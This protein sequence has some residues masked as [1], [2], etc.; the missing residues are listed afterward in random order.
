MG[1]LKNRWAMLALLF[2][3][4]ASMAMQF[5]LIPPIVPFLIEDLGINFTQVGLL[6]GLFMAAGIFLALPAGLLGQRFGDKA[7]VLTGLAV[8]T[9]GAVLFANAE[10]F[11]LAF[12][13]RLLGGVGVVLLNVQL[14]K[15]TA[16]W[17][18]DKEI[19]TAMGIL[20]TAWPLGLST[21]GYVATVYSWQMAI[22]ITAAYSGISLLLF[23]LLYSD[24]P[25]PEKAREPGSKRPG[26]WSISKAELVMIV[27]AGLVWVLPNAGFVVFLS[28]TPTLLMAGGMAVAQ[29]GFTVSLASWISIGSIPTG[30]WLTDRTGRINLFIVAGCT[31]CALAIFLLPI[32]GA[33]L[34]WVV[35]FGVALG[36]WPGAIMALP[37]KVLSPTGRSTGFGVFYSVY[38]LGM[39]IF[40]PFAGWL[41]DATGKADASVMFGGLLLA[42]AVFALAVFRM[43][44][45][46]WLPKEELATGAAS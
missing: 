19:S 32:G 2:F 3:A 11:S 26:V 10:S 36:G 12:V 13:G 27:A 9:V 21:L 22:Y 1:L 20:M 34:V 46:R 41:Q 6:I 16:D 29:A 17:F 24:P 14:T 35:V 38:Y 25:F 4:R 15:I 37:G 8:M 31:V 28:F 7:V 33:V 44:Q 45:K 5:Q 23:A 43:L 40:L 18:A 30:G 39:A 42:L